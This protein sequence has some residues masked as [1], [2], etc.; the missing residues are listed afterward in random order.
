MKDSMFESGTDAC[1]V[2]NIRLAG[3]AVVVDDTG[4]DT[5][6][7]VIQADFE[8]GIADYAWIV[9]SSYSYGWI[10]ETTVVYDGL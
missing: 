2:D 4:D 1:Y 5:T 6:C 9:S 7:D 3:C 10:D 8:N